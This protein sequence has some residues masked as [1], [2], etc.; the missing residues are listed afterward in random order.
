LWNKTIL[1]DFGVVGVD[2]VYPTNPLTIGSAG[3]LYSASGSGGSGGGGTA[4][5]LAKVGGIW[6]EKI[7][8][9]FPNGG[10]VGSPNGGVALDSAGNLYGT[11]HN[12]GA[13]GAGGVYEIVP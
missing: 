2:T 10:G 7:L 1:Y 11:G 3:Q 4:Y 6:K 12:G 5:E 9:N 13:F 8:Y